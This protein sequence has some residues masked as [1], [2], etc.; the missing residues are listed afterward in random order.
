MNKDKII[1]A[2]LVFGLLTA[3]VKFGAAVCALVKV[4]PSF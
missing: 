3:V 4:L 2:T 1:I